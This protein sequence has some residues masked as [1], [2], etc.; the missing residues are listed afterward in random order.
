MPPRSNAVLQFPHKTTPILIIRKVPTR[1]KN[2]DYRSREYLTEDEVEKLMDVADKVGRHGHRDTTLIM[3]AYRHVLR[4]TELVSLRWVQA[5][6]DHLMQIMD[7][8]NQKMGKGTLTIAASGTNKRWAM[9]RENK[10]PNYTTEWS[11][12]PEAW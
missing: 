5:K 4:V 12:L 1:L 7:Q 11:E 6:T 9:R 8:I 10:S 2:T 3:L